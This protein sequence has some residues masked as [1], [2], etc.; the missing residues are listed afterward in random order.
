MASQAPRK[1]RI[2][3]SCAS[4]CFLIAALASPCGAA[5]VPSSPYLPVIYRFADAML[6]QGCDVHGPQKTGLMLSALDRTTLAPLT[7]RPAAP[8][9]IRESD[10]DGP[11]DGPLVGA[12][13]QHDQN[14]LRVLYTLSEL[15]G[16]P[17]YRDAADAELRFFLR[18]AA[19]PTTGL[20]PWGE[21]MSWNVLTDRPIPDQADAPGQ[22]EF[23]RPWVLWDRCFE[24]EPD[25]SKRFALALWEHQIAGHATGAFDRHAGYWKHAATDGMDFA[26]HAGFY[27]RT[28]A[29]AHAHTKDRTFLTAIQT[30]LSRYEKK[31]HPTTG[32]IELRTGRDDASPVLSLSLAIDCDAA[33]RLVPEPL[34]SRLRNFAAR[35]DEILCQLPHDL[36]GKSGFISSCDKTT[37]R[38]DDSSITPLWELRYGTFTTA[39]VAMMCVSRYEN[40]GK[41]GYRQLIDD[42]ADAYLDRMPGDAVDLWPMSLGHAI[43][44][45]LAAWRSTARPVHLDHARKLADYGLKTFWAGGDLPRASSRTNHYET[46]TGSDTL[47]LALVELHLSIL[48]ITA[49]RCP[50]NTIDR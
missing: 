12:N 33:A 10:R 13:P 2:C 40:T 41:I 30:L 11:A 36:K 48:H 44:L 26:R 9:G 43:S 21:H 23:A 34:A 39:T 4:M 25:A 8:A 7:T 1:V 19:S 45:Q 47:A 3:Q 15:S 22:H 24:L 20:L 28:W 32:L 42:A 38:R 31:R 16:R 6:Q 17:V 18:N 5:D 46:I 27:I 29:V 50:A 37:G 14:L 49:V 35:E